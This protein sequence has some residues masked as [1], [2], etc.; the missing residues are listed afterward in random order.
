MHALTSRV[1]VT[2]MAYNIHG[3]FIVYTNFEVV[4]G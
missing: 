3:N 2:C 1:C 4:H